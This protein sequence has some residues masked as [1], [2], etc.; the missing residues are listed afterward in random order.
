MKYHPVSL[1]SSPDVHYKLVFLLDEIPQQKILDSSFWFMLLRMQIW[2]SESHNAALLYETLLPFLSGKPLAATVYENLVV[3]EKKSDKPPPPPG[4]PPGGSS[5]AFSNP[6]GDSS[7][8]SGGSGGSSGS[9]SVVSVYDEA[10]GR[11]AVGTLGM[12]EDMPPWAPLPRAGD[13]SMFHC[14]MHASNFVLLRYILISSIDE[15]LLPLT[16]PLVPVR[17]SHSCV[18]WYE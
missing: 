4:P 8:G 5:H 1:D 15:S 3:E 11:Y 14:V 10:K 16:S 18:R 13:M 9:T 6:F 17:S 12:G 2:P 7:S